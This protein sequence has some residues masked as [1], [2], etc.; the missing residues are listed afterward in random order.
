MLGTGTANASVDSA[1]YR[2]YKSEVIPDNLKYVLDWEKVYQY[3]TYI[4]KE[5]ADR[6]K[7][8]VDREIKEKGIN[9]LTIQTEW[10]CNF[11]TATNRFITLEDIRNN[12]LMTEEMDSNLSFYTDKDIYRIGI[13]DPSISGD[14]SAFGTAIGGYDDLFTWIKIKNLEVLKE[15]NEQIDPDELIDK[16]IK[17]CKS[18][19]LDYLVVDDTAG[20]K[21]LT[22][23]LYKRLKVETKTQLIPM[24]YSGSVAKARMSRYNEGHIVRQSIK[25]PR[26]DYKVQSKAFEYLLTELPLLE[27]KETNYGYSYKAMGESNDDFA[28]V[29]LMAGYSLEF[30]RASIED[31]KDFIIGKYSHRLYFRKWEAEPEVSKPFPKRYMLVL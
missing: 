20:Q 11:N 2:Y 22:S 25:I 21:Y 27:K 31:K 24:D 28:M 30:L 16:V 14:R 19:T 29:F 3:K 23:P 7:V 26:E 18:N 6:Y 12:N 5:H 10:Y 15:L 1:L 4:S 9:S 13:L 17:L 8:T